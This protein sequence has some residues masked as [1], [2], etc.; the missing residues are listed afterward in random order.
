[1]YETEIQI[2]QENEPYESLP[3]LKCTPNV[4]D[5]KTGM[6][7][8]KILNENLDVTKTSSVQHANGSHDKQNCRQN[9]NFEIWICNQNKH[10]TR[11][12]IYYNQ[13]NEPQQTSSTSNL[14]QMN[15]NKTIYK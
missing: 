2:Y 5:K 14:N 10:S 13:A 11:S 1:M 15:H 9:S 8:A 3:E 7:W 4:K 6:T 12:R